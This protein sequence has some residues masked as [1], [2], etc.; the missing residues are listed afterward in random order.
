M[1]LSFSPS[2]LASADLFK[3]KKTCISQVFVWFCWHGSGFDFARTQSQNWP[4]RDIFSTELLAML[5][6]GVNPTDLCFYKRKVQ[7]QHMAY[8]QVVSLP[9]K[10]SPWY[11]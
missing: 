7:A 10:P 3:E 4:L 9:Y 1:L 8:L 11:H 6:E 2:L 5:V